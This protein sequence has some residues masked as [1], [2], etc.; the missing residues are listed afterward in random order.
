MIMTAHVFNAGLDPQWPATLSQR[1]IGGLLRDS[2]GFD[3]IVISDDLQMKAISAQYGVDTAVQR[4]VL[5]GVDVLLFGNN[6]GSYDEGIARRAHAI[7]REL[8]RRGVV[9]AQR[10]DASYHRI[11]RAKQRLGRP[12]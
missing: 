5:A 2:L 7:L 9:S 10:I 1:V 6:T 11:L 3:G 8:L 12:R 4:A